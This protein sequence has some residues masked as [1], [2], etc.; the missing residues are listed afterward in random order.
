MARYKIGIDVGG[1]FTDFLLM[2]ADG[3]TEIY[4]VLSTSEDPSLALLE[5]LRQMADGHGTTLA[6]FLN[7]VE[8]IVHG[9]T[10]TTNAVLTGRVART[11]LLTT[12]GFRDALQM[13]RGIREET[14]DNKAKPPEP[15]VPRWLRRPVGERVTA[16][17]AVHT[18]LDLADVE[19]A[20]VRFREA[21]VEA[22]AICFMHAYANP[23]HEEAAAACLAKALPDVYCS[24]SSAVLPQV[25]FYDRISTTVLNAAVGPILERYLRNLTERLDKAGFGGIL[26]IMQSNGGVTTPAVAAKLA[27][28]TLL[29]GPAAA[30]VAGLA[31]S[32]PHGGR[33]FITVDMGGTSFDAALVRDG[34]P[35]LTTDARIAKHALALPSLEINTIGAGGGSIGW[36]DEG[37]LLRMGPASAGADP[38]PACYGRGGELPTCSDANLVLG[39][40]S[41]DFFAGGRL[42]LDRDAAAGAIDRMIAMPLG[43]DLAEAAFGMFRMM[44]VNMAS[45][46]REITVQK[47][48]DP[49]DFPLICAGGAGPIHAAMIAEELEIGRILIPRESSIFCAAGMLRSDL[50]HDYVRSYHTR[51]DVDGLDA[52]RFQDALRSM[53]AEANQTLEGEAIAPDARR[54]T[55]ALD[56]RYLGQ[57]H[58]V[59]VEVPAAELHGPDFTAIA[60]RL[61]ANHNRLYGYD[62]K[63]DGTEIELVNLRLSATGITEKPP[64]IRERRVDGDAVA[65]RKGRRAVFLPHEGQYRDTD[66]FDGDQLRHGTH[67]E[68]PAIVEQVNTSVLVPG[69]YRLDCDELGSFVMEKG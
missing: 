28:S 56:L 23:A 67:I 18:P 30:P 27:A 1:T 54:F 63:A 9:T 2:E 8:I 17:G 20:A 24:V 51:F 40:L 68:G 65:A 3:T 35:E 15:L 38:G 66:V 13:R 7:A 62:L 21:G 14:Y 29:S 22:A 42:A 52:M 5:G 41:A 45:G 55:N 37:G 36:I 49:R 46:I 58:E 12:K 39:Y 10:V 44:N 60:E 48:F 6:D 69:G 34:A 19:E 61:H 31:Y 47:G 57:Y 33:S 50:K 59:R 4:K 43:L 16:D 26:L 11:G 64:M 32:E 53:A 25:R